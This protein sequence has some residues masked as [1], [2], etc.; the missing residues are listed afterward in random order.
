MPAWIN[1]ARALLQ[2]ERQLALREAEFKTAQA[3]VKTY[4]KRLDD[5]EKARVAAED[6]VYEPAGIAHC[7]S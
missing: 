3:Q 7:H 4:Q 6:E 2:A 5:A 1:M